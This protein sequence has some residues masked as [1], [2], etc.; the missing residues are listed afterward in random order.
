MTQGLFK[1]AAEE[2]ARQQFNAKNQLQGGFF[3]E[4]EAQVETPNKNRVSAMAQYNA[5]EANSVAQFNSSL[6]DARDKFNSNMQFAIDQSNVNWRRQVNT[7]TSQYKMKQ[8]DNI[9]NLYNASQNTLNNLWQKYRDNAS[10]NF[11]KSES[12]LQRQHESWYN[13]NGIC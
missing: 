6:R 2:N 7:A 10:W 12:F 5:G 3:A 4:L 8:I 9:Q 1:D 13:G 11:Q